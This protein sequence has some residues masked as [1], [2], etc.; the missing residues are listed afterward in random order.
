MSE[1]IT[2]VNSR[3]KFMVQDEKRQIIDLLN[4]STGEN[5]LMPLVYMTNDLKRVLFF[6]DDAFYDFSRGEGEYDCSAKKIPYDDEKSVLENIVEKFY[7]LTDKKYFNEN[8]LNELYLDSDGTEALTFLNR[9]IN[10]L[11]E[12]IFFMAKED[13]L[14]DAEGHKFSDQLSSLSDSY[15]AAKDIYNELQ[16]L[17]SGKYDY[18]LTVRT[19]LKVASDNSSMNVMNDI[20]TRHDKDAVSLSSKDELRLNRFRLCQAEPKKACLLI[21]SELYG[22]NPV[23]RAKSD[24]A[25]R[26]AQEDL[27][28]QMPGKYKVLHTL[29]ISE[30][31]EDGYLYACL[32]ENLNG[33]DDE[34]KFVVWG[35]MNTDTGSLN[36]GSYDLSEESAFRILLNKIS[37]EIKFNTKEFAR[38]FSVKD[39]IDYL[40]VTMNDSQE[41]P[42]SNEELI[43]TSQKFIKGLGAGQRE[44]LNEC[45]V[46]G[47]VKSPENL[48][49]FIKNELKKDERNKKVQQKKDGYERER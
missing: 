5:V 20:V 23:Y 39:F 14:A 22:E 33:H 24:N 12:S 46:S 16:I 48:L 43:L 30:N 3:R 2:D 17:P 49:S 31:K 36:W 4:G 25:K 45:L 37:P 29:P 15:D 19:M 13:S 9:N 21:Q 40:K 6:T 26:L 8:S 10:L 27:D 32:A 44:K 1:K 34:R 35:S 7:E 18:N 42:V 28:R 11:E 38:N 47:G 41:K